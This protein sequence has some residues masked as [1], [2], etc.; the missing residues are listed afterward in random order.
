[1]RVTRDILFRRLGHLNRYYKREGYR[2]EID[3]ETPGYGNAK[4]YKL[5]WVNTNTD[6][7]QTF[8]E[9]QDRMTINEFDCY[10]TALFT[11]VGI[12]LVKKA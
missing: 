8:S 1:M 10:L 2:L 9:T 11:A 4:G 7:Q 5:V 3:Y 12:L 6:G